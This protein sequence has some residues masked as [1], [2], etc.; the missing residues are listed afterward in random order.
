MTAAAPE[1]GPTTEA[2]TVLAEVR[3]SSHARALADLFGKQ[4]ELAGVY[5][6][7]DVTAEAVRWSA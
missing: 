2:P 6:P 1:T 4:P 7:A 3:A 5:S